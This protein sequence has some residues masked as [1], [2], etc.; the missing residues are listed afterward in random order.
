[1]RAPDLGNNPNTF[2]EL[3]FIATKTIYPEDWITWYYGHFH[4]IFK[5]T[6][7]D[8][9]STDDSD[10]QSD[11]D[12]SDDDMNMAV[13][14]SNQLSE[15]HKMALALQQSLNSGIEDQA[16][17]VVAVGSSS[18]DS[19]DE[20][21][22]D[23]SR[24]S[25]KRMNEQ[26]ELPEGD[27]RVKYSKRRLNIAGD[28]HAPESTPL[29][30]GVP[31][32]NSLRIEDKCYIASTAADGLVRFQTCFVKALVTN[33]SLG[34][35]TH[36]DVSLGKFS[37][38]THCAIVAVQA[39]EDLAA[40]ATAKQKRIEENRKSKEIQDESDRQ[41]SAARYASGDLVFREE[42]S[43][44]H[45]PLQE[46]RRFES[47][48]AP[49]PV[50]GHLDQMGDGAHS[51]HA[52]VSS[53]DEEVIRALEDEIS[54]DENECLNESGME[55]NEL[56]KAEAE[57]TIELS[58][59]S[60]EEIWAMFV[61][62]KMKGGSMARTLF[63]AGK[64]LESKI[65]DP[66]PG[67]KKLETKK[68]D[69]ADQR[70]SF[71]MWAGTTRVINW[72]RLE[73]FKIIL[74]KPH[75]YKTFSV[76]HATAPKTLVSSDGK[77]ELEASQASNDTMARIAHLACS[78]DSRVYL[79]MIF[80][81]KSLE[82]VDAPDLQPTQ[83]W[84]DLASVF[85]NN[86]TWNI[87]QIDVLQLQQVS[88]VKGSNV[89][90]SLIDVSKAPI[91]GITGECLRLVF[92]EVKVMWKDLADRVHG[93]TG[94]NTTGEDLYGKVWSNYI[95]GK[96]LYFARP[97]VAMYVFKLWNEAHLCDNLPKYC[98]KELNKEAQVRIGVGEQ[99]GKFQLPCQTPKG[100]SGSQ[101][102]TSPS[103]PSSHD[104]M[105]AMTSYFQ[106]K[107]EEMKQGDNISA[108]K[109][110]SVAPKFSQVTN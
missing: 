62:K 109:A 73:L 26:D 79:N 90:S 60:A 4:G 16:A 9:S 10:S 25:S 29:P 72:I 95:N 44:G 34:L 105:T 69:V 31:I 6:S 68:A 30:S 80:G 98:I 17:E 92:N 108:A 52:N 15:D 19:V 66:W 49:I 1:V 36:Y 88:I 48:Y 96:L 40:H 84:Q 81:R 86:S 54:E 83:L 85:V 59:C 13:K 3:F 76:T 58:T 104:T 71:L 5:R 103:T 100:S 93:R 21:E 77:Y 107:L 74:S 53:E 42:Q 70:K 63:I 94:S 24:A 110:S 8:D 78:A 102:F 41:E 82:C 56:S 33:F 2:C 23:E 32:A 43:P 67:D 57:L 18:S 51:A 46:A 106:L 45:S 91:I 101:G 47:D 75:T 55:A 35:V 38:P 97:E 89:T 87:R 22:K 14:L 7:S 61:N 37:N 65:C 27:V 12:D 50:F 28:A 99:S 11:E 20:V 64:A 39:H